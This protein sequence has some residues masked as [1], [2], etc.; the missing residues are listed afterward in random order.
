M[1]RIKKSALEFRIYFTIGVKE[2][3]TFLITAILFSMVIPFGVI[4][5]VKMMSATMDQASTVVYISGNMI[6]AISNLCITTLAQLLLNARAKNG[7]EH[8][9]TLPISRWSPL[10]GML[11]SS[12]IATFPSLFLMP[13]IAMKMFHVTFRVTP[14]LIFVLLLSLFI[15]I[16][17]GA[18]IGTC[19]ENYVVCNTV[20]MVMMFFV[21]FGTPVYY[22]IDALPVFVQYFQ[23]LLPFTYMVESMRHIMV[24]GVNNQVVYRDIIVLLVYAIVLFLFTNK[25]FQWKQK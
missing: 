15:M 21:M 3:A 22:S 17:M 2:Q 12:A 18:I 19:S 6:T 25:Y 9:A 13:L 5:M 23:R 4:F 14:T 10:F 16:N 7:F 1:E 24:F 20:S 11:G 8:M